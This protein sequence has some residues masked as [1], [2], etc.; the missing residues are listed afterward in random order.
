MEAIIKLASIIVILPFIILEAII[1]ATMFI[2]YFPIALGVAFLYPMLKHTNI[3]DSLKNWYRY[4]T[5]W[6]NGF[7]TSSLFDLWEI[8]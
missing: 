1:K 6:R 7:L 5:K 8:D 4:S 2:L 3:L